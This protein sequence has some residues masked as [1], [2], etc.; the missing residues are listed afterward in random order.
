[1]YDSG[2]QMYAPYNG[3]AGGVGQGGAQPQGGQAQPGAQQGQ[4][5]AYGVPQTPQGFGTLGYV[6]PSYVNPQQ[7]QQYMD[8]YE[9]LVSKGLQPTFQQE[10]QQLQDSNAARGISNSG[11]A[12]Y[13]QSD[14]LGEQAGVVAGAQAP[15]VSQGYG[16]TQQDLQGN[17]QAANAA[18]FYNAGTYNNYENELMT[19]YLNSFGPN[20]GVSSA[21]GEGIGGIGSTVGGV[22]GSA[23][24]GEGSALGGLGEGFGAYEG[25]AAEAAAAG[26]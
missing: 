12:S 24:Q 4:G 22:Y 15:I 2:D 20:T 19:G 8:Q 10:D 26:G 21:Y 9:Q 14:L 18:S 25:A 6:N 13:L 7:S 23:L 5:G 17:Q 1:M 16:Y 11:A 3:G